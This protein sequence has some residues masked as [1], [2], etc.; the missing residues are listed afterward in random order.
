MCVN[1]TLF[2]TLLQLQKSATC[3]LV[4]QDSNHN[5]STLSQKIICYFTYL[6]DIDIKLQ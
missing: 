2:I 3:K 1:A 6:N 4:N 5:F